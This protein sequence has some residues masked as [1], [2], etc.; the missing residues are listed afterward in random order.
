[1]L[2]ANIDPAIEEV[3]YDFLLIRRLAGMAP[4]QAPGVD[5][6]LFERLILQARDSHSRRIAASA[7]MRSGSSSATNSSE[8]YRSPHFEAL[9]R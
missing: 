4:D 6:G 5:T 8:A 7:A 2:N 1:M 9:A 3:P